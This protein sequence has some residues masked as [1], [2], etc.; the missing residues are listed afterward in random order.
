MMISVGLRTLVALGIG[1]PLTVLIRQ[2][3]RPM[4]ASSM[5]VR[6]REAVLALGCEDFAG[7]RL[8][9]QAGDFP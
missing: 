5:R 7:R 8:K 2:L 3:N 6:E 9:Q 1:L 4:T